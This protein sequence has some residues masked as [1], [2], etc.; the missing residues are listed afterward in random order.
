ML[1]GTLHVRLGREEE[2]LLRKGVL[3]FALSQESYL[4]IVNC[5]LNSR[6]LPHIVHCI[7]QYQ[8]HGNDYEMV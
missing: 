6:V 5:N 4:G 1:R 2:A 3:Y 8:S 7:Q